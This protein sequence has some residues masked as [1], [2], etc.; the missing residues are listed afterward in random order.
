MKSINIV[1]NVILLHYIN[2]ALSFQVQPSTSHTNHV[3]SLVDRCSATDTAKMLSSSS[4]STS[5]EQ[6]HLYRLTSTTLFSQNNNN[7]EDEFGVGPKYDGDIDWDSEWK[8]VV[9][10]QDQPETRPGKDFYK[11][12]VEKALGK[13]AKAAQEQISK[14]PNVKVEMPKPRVPMSLT[15]DAKLWLGIIAILSIGSAVIGASGSINADY[16]ANGVF[17][18]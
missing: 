17:D 11:N 4:S 1:R 7:N 8:K 14:I 12:D 6:N 13:T 10:N 9:E 5:Q 18:I 15:G 2:D 16:T 3:T